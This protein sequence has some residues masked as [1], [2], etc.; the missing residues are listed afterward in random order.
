MKIIII[1]AIGQNF[2]IGKDGKIPWHSSEEF[3][4]FKSATMGSPMIMGRKTFESI[5]KPLPGR[6]SIVISSNEILIL[7]AGVKKFSSIGAALDFCEKEN[8][9]KVFIIGG[10]SIYKEAINFAD[11]LI[12]SVMNLNPEGD[13]FFPEINDQIWKENKTEKFE[14]FS[15][16]YFARIK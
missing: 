13:T 12:I 9:E 4:H 6:L 2:V 1:S 10:G 11:E 15:V 3:R 14:E 5:G 7:P 16:K 8:Q